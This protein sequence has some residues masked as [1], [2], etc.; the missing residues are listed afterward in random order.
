MLFPHRA[1]NVFKVKDYSAHQTAFNDSAQGWEN[2]W[3][4]HRVAYSHLQTY[5]IPEEGIKA[6]HPH[7]DTE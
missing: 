6:T 5:P 4:I 2:T 7:P 3:R 1:A